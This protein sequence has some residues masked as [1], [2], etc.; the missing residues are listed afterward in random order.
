M[1]LGRL[2]I[3]NTSVH[4]NGGNTCKDTIHNCGSEQSVKMWLDDLKNEWV[5]HDINTKG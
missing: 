1:F 5:G 3:R 2:W 4:N